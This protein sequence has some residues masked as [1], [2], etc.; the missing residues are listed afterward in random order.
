M[1]TEEIA[2][3]IGSTD[4]KVRLCVVGLVAI[5]L[6]WFLLFAYLGSG[7]PHKKALFM[8]TGMSCKTDQ[9]S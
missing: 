7:V 6:G 3:S 4:A 5:M 2:K 8:A 9:G 1:K